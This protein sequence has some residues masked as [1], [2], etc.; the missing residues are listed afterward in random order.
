MTTASPTLAVLPPADDL[1]TTGL[2]LSGGL[3]STI[4]LGQLLSH[5]WRVRPFYVCT[6]CAWQ[7]EELDA[8]HRLLSELRQPHLES[9]VEL[10][11]TV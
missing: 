2:L 10:K 1:Q 11:K 5:G 4:L 7:N 9:L 6:G 8:V 3:D